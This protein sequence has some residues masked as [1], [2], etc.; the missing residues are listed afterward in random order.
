MKM[1]DAMK[2]DIPEADL[3]EHAKLI[4]AID[5]AH[6]CHDGVAEAEQELAEYLA[7]HPEITDYYRAV[8]Q[9]HRTQSAIAE[10]SGANIFAPFAG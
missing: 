8:R 4:D 5:C 3:A 1:L 2:A 10:I 7:K 9:Y 6:D